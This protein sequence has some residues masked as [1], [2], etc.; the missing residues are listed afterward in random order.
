[1]KVI[2]LHGFASSPASSKARFFTQKFKGAGF[3]VSVP[4]LDGGNFR[5][6]TITS[7]LDI[8]ERAA[9]GS[10]HVILMGS[11]RKSVV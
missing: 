8:V 9:S 7:Q 10:E 3:D 2:Y 11:D 5:N 4:A 6:L 1:M